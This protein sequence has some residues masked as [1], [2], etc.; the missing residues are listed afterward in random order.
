MCWPGVKTYNQQSATHNEIVEWRSRPW[1]PPTTHSSI[2]KE[3]LNFSFFIHGLSSLFNQSN[4]MKIDWFGAPSIK[5]FHF[6]NYG[7]MGYMLLAHQTQTSFLF[8]W[9]FHLSLR[10][11]SE[12]KEGRQLGLDWSEL[13]IP[14]IT[15]HPAIQINLL[16]WWREQLTIP[17][18]SIAFIQRN[19]ITFI[20]FWIQQFLWKELV[21]ERRNDI[22]TVNW[23]N[24]WIQH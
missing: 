14:H 17:F 4:G 5:K 2:H 8:D 1:R 22:I 20:S 11:R 24:G 10:R 6:F 13:V 19:K 18:N 12:I 16:I 9:L 3:K 21:S 7:V 23:V 15:Q